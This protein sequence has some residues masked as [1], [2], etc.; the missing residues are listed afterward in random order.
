LPLPVL[1]VARSTLFVIPEG[2]LLLSLPLSVLAVPSSILFVIPE[3]DLRLPLPLLVLAVILSA[4]KNPI[5]SHIP[6]TARTFLPQKPVSFASLKGTASAVPQP[7]PFY[8]G[9]SR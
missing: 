8:Y 2:N 1:A 3:G 9:F 5:A 7:L 6:E 4:A